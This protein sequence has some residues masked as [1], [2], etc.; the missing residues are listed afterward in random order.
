MWNYFFYCLNVKLHWHKSVKWLVFCDIDLKVTENTP[1]F[2]LFLFQREITLMTYC[3]FPLTTKSF[4]HRVYSLRNE[5]VPR[6]ANSFSLRIDSL[7]EGRQKEKKNGR[8]AFHEI[9]LIH[10]NPIALRKPKI[11]YNFGLS[12]CSRIKW[13]TKWEKEPYGFSVQPAQTSMQ[14]DQILQTFIYNLHIQ[15]NLVN[16]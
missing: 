14:Y 10:L 8:V 5:F 13:D 2:I 3:L 12:E 15:R 11:V 6:G 4:K 7:W 9:E 1:M 16:V